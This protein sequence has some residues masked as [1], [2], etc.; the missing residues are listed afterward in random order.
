MR[1]STAIAIGQRDSPITESAGRLG[2]SIGWILGGDIDLLDIVGRTRPRRAG[3]PVLGS[4]PSE[5]PGSRNIPG[6]WSAIV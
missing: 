6:P 4:R 5:T 1:T 2:R 3:Q